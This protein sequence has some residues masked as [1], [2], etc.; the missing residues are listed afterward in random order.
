M[1]EIVLCRECPRLVRYREEIAREKRLAFRDWEYWGKPVPGF[2]DPHAR[3]LI[4][5]PGA[6]RARGKSHRPHVHW[7]P[8]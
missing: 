1:N 7:R 8:L 3:L 6:R 4:L 5:G 2:G